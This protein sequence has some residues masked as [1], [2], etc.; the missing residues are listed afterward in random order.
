MLRAAHVRQQ[1]NTR[2]ARWVCMLVSKG[3]QV[4][5]L[6]EHFHSAHSPFK[7]L[8]MLVTR[9]AQATI[10]SQASWTEAEYAFQ[11]RIVPIIMEPSYKASGWLGTLMGMRLYFD[12]SDAAKNQSKVRSR[13]RS[14]SR[15]SRSLVRACVCVC[16]DQL[17]G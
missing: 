2:R 14:A 13:S 4:L 9:R 15:S 6:H 1:K 8:V 5:R 17:R 3:S 7:T 16:V 12:M 10:P 11:Q